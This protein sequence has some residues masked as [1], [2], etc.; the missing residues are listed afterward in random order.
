MLGARADSF[1]AADR[2]I[3][4]KVTSTALPF[5]LP[6]LLLPRIL[7]VLRFE[8]FDPFLVVVAMA[9]VLVCRTVSCVSRESCDVLET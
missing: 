9:L 3:S 7:V 5:P 6:P 8:P 1:V 4:F 2:G